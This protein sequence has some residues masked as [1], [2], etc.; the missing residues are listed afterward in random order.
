MTAICFCNTDIGCCTVG[1][2]A[3]EITQTKILADRLF[4]LWSEF[5]RQ[6]TWNIALPENMIKG[7]TRGPNRGRLY[8]F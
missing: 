2:D 3:G 1:R 8:C 4:Y 6:P 7:G 5:F